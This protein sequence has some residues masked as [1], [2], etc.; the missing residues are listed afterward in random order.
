MDVPVTGETGAAAPASRDA[1]SGS[2]ATVVASTAD[3]AVVAASERVV[4][5]ATTASSV[6]LMDLSGY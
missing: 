1:P 2:T 3:A 6:T 5:S 4:E